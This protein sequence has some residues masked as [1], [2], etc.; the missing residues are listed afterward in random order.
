MPTLDLE[1]STET[2]SSPGLLDQ[3]K[4]I[5]LLP[6]SRPAR[7]AA[8]TSKGKFNHPCSLALTSPVQEQEQ[9]CFLTNAR[10]TVI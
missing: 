2:T 7:V 3:R 4:K 8:H 10:K 6:K 1:E 9:F 5:A